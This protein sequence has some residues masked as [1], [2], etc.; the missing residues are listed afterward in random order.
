MRWDGMGWAGLTIKEGRILGEGL[1]GGDGVGRITQEKLVLSVDL[2]E[3]MCSGLDSSF[4]F[5][6]G[7]LGMARWSADY[8]SDGLGVSFSSFLTP[9]LAQQSS[10]RLMSFSSGGHLFSFSVFL[11]EIL[12]GAEKR[13]KGGGEDIAVFGRIAAQT[14]A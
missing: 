8:S 6:P 3:Y 5:L 13:L 11:R 10:Q 2:E 12:V 9:V 4:C 7:S 14:S 1:G